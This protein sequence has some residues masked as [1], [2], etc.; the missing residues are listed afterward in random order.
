M[1][2]R[3]ESLGAYWSFGNLDKTMLLTVN[4]IKLC[5]ILGL[6]VKLKND[7]CNFLPMMTVK[8]EKRYFNVTNVKYDCHHSPP[9]LPRKS[10]GRVPIYCTV[11]SMIIFIAQVLT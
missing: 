2:D 8:W 10:L 3:W 7:D 11:T 6:N 4:E 9:P 1:C 5:K